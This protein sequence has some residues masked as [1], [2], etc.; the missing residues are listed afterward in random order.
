[1]DR[2]VSGLVSHRIWKYVLT[3]ALTRVRLG[4][5]LWTPLSSP[6]EPDPRRCPNRTRY[7]GE[8]GT[9]L[10]YPYAGRKQMLFGRLC[11]CT[12]DPSPLHPDPRRVAAT[13]MQRT[14]FKPSHGN[15]WVAAWIQFQ[16]H[17]WMEH[18]IDPDSDPLV[19][20]SNLSQPDL[21]L[22]GP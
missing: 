18:Q 8:R 2:L 20:G 21:T 4:M 11:L 22:V 13:L 16:V 9:S 7:R 5:E 19:P 10:V 17:G 14:T 1:M 15:L 3:G 6:P 12:S